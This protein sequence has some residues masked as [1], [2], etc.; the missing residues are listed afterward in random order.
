MDDNAVT[1]ILT[2]SPTL[3]V[4]V[5]TVIYFLKHMERKDISTNTVIKEV[6]DNVKTLNTTLCLL[7]KD[8]EQREGVVEKLVST[9]DGLNDTL[10]AVRCLN[11]PQ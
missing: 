2:Q 8:I 10:R 9:V 1:A 3:G 4:L 7:Q 11:H 6:S 5:F